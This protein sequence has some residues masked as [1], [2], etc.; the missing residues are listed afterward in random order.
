MSSHYET[1]MSTDAS[2]RS[3][4]RMTGSVLSLIIQKFQTR[5]PGTPDPIAMNPAEQAR[6]NSWNEGFTAYE[7]GQSIEANGAYGR[8]RPLWRE[9]WLAAKRVDELLAGKGEL[10]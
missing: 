6:F 4:E 10:L 1:G 9:G 8:A 7:N 3:T 2:S 5:A